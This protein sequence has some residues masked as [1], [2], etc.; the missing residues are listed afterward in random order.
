MTNFSSLFPSFC[1]QCPLPESSHCQILCRPTDLVKNPNRSRQD[2]VK[3]SVGLR[4]CVG[5][6]GA[7]GMLPPLSSQL[8]QKKCGFQ[9]ACRQCI[10]TRN[11]DCHQLRET[12]NGQPGCLAK[13]PPRQPRETPEAYQFRSSDYVEYGSGFEQ[14][15]PQWV[16][17]GARNISSM[18]R[19]F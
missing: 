7:P 10:F 13:P 5:R 18:L 12:R 15:V 14:T 11:R 3:N 17:L 16:T 1:A 8:T 19:L 4:T 6:A 9:Y 2:L